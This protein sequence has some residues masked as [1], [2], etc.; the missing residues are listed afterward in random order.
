[1]MDPLAT[2]PPGRW[3]HGDVEVMR[4]LVPQQESTLTALRSGRGLTVTHRL[5]PSDLSD[6]LATRVADELELRTPAD[7]EAVIVGLVRSTVSDPRAAWALYYDNSL[8]ELLAG[9]APFARVHEYGAALVEGG[10][11][12]DLGSCFGFFALRL[13]LAGHRVTATDICDGTMRLLSTVAVDLGIGIDTLACDAAEVPLPDESAD[14][15][16][17]IHL[18]E[19]V[20]PEVGARIVAEAVRVARRRVVIAVPF[21]DEPTVC[22]GHV[23][24]FDLATLHE[25][26]AATGHRHRVAEHHGGWLVI[27]L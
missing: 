15:V 26:G 4:S 22:H 7:F 12:V 11:V 21:E 16:T 5:R 2:C 10:T 14:T 23:R 25:L 3:R 17:A 27:D 9:T 13:A 20:D 1:M 8:R 24:T 6:R 18:L 19:H